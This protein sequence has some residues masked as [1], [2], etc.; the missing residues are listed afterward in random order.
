MPVCDRTT[1]TFTADAWALIGAWREAVESMPFIVALADGSLPTDA[2]AFYLAQDALY[3]TEFARVLARAS[4]LAPSRDAQAF[5]ASSAHTALEVE[6][7]L[8]RDWLG[9]HA[10]AAPNAIDSTLPSPATAGYTNHLL[11]IA[12][13][14][15]YAQVVAAVLP[16]YWLYA[17][18]GDVLIELAAGVPDHPY[19]A[20]IDTYADPGFQDATRQARAFAD[21]AARTVDEAERAR[22]LR[23]FEISSM[24]EF[25]FFAQG[26]TKPH[27]PTAETFIEA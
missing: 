25:L 3:L 27:W 23:A 11:A 4:Q 7:S 2:F 20:W 19:R 18:I 24:H 13:M 10:G 26:L 12:A 8:H 22:M 14:G 1:A 6:S 16:C 17:H 15:S 21:A 5:F 9:K